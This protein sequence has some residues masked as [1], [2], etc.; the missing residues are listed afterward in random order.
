MANPAFFCEWEE[1]HGPRDQQVSW[2]QGT[3]WRVLPNIVSIYRER[4]GPRW[5]PRADDK[6]LPGDGLASFIVSGTNRHR[7]DI[8]GPKYCHRSPSLRLMVSF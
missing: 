8:M 7:D 2:D 1:P 3:T 4:R 6:S 5:A